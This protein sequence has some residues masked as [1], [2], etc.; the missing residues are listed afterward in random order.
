M[1]KSEGSSHSDAVMAVFIKAGKANVMLDQF[2]SKLP[3]SLTGVLIFGLM[4]VS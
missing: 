1:L 3:R 2:W 4:K